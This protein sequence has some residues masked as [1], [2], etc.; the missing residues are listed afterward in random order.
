[1]RQILLPIIPREHLDFGDIVPLFCTIGALDSQDHLF[2]CRLPVFLPSPTFAY[3]PFDDGGM[4]DCFIPQELAAS[5]GRWCRRRSLNLTTGVRMSRKQRNFVLR[6]A[7]GYRGG[8]EGVCFT[9]HNVALNVR[10]FQW[11]RVRGILDE[12]GLPLRHSIHPP[13]ASRY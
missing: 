10:P 11:F 2:R 1:M 4:K 13:A 8:V 12:D 7:T 6:R 3:L 5:N 9:K